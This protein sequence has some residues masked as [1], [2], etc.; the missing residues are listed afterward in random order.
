MK[1]QLFKFGLKNG[2][3][4][5]VTGLPFSPIK[6]PDA[7]SIGLEGATGR[8]LLGGNTQDIYIAKHKLSNPE[9]PITWR[10]IS[11]SPTNKYSETMALFNDNIFYEQ[12]SGDGVYKHEIAFPS[13]HTGSLIYP[14]VDSVGIAVESYGTVWVVD[15]SLNEIVG[16]DGDGIGQSIACSST[17]LS[18]IATDFYHTSPNYKIRYRVFAAD[19]LGKRVHRAT[20][21]LASN[22]LLDYSYYENIFDD[23]NPY[24]VGIDG[25]NNAWCFGMGTSSIVKIYRVE[26]SSVF[27]FG[28]NCRYPTCKLEDYEGYQNVMFNDLAIEWFL[29]RDPELMSAHAKMAYYALLVDYVENEVAVNPSYTRYFG[30]KTISGFTR[31]EKIQN[32]QDWNRTF[33]SDLNNC[34]GRKMFINYESAPASNL[35]DRYTSVAP[36]TYMSPP[37]ALSDFTGKVAIDST[38]LMV[39]MQRTEDPEHVH[40]LESSSSSVVENIYYPH[41]HRTYVSNCRSL[42]AINNP[43]AGSDTGMI[44][45]GHFDVCYDAYE[46][47]RS[48]KHIE[49]GGLRRNIVNNG[50]ILCDNASKLFSMGV[51]GVSLTLCL[52]HAITNGV[53]ETLT[54]EQ[55]SLI[56]DKLMWAVNM[57]DMY[58]TQPGLYAA[59]TPDG[60]E[61]TSWSH[62]SKTTIVDT[63]INVPENT[64]FTIDFVWN[65]DGLFDEIPNADIAIFLDGELKSWGSGEIGDDSFDELYKRAN[66]TPKHAEFCLMGNKSRLLTLDG[67]IR[68]IE[69]YTS[70]RLSSSSSSQDSLSSSSQSHELIGRGIASLPLSFWSSKEPV[71]NIKDVKFGTVVTQTTDLGLTRESGSFMHRF[72]EDKGRGLKTDVVLPELGIDLPP[73]F[74]L[75]FKL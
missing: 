60:I 75:V 40:V 59:F 57:G 10:L 58:I 27:P 30:G 3:L 45:S 16:I 51:G 14:S 36:L 46:Y 68:R 73:G 47:D 72:G 1:Q 28:G 12:R 22:T 35:G 25:F 48:D 23:D 9:E 50:I 53:Y 15:N 17:Y 11:R 43:M 18:G 26:N 70:P 8:L 71:V 31:L 63:S 37:N 49:Q 69:T 74:D 34:Q 2:K 65:K 39:D 20:Y 61:F 54:G 52:P 56:K 62:L 4:Y 5:S 13:I 7:R 42:S 67:I 41:R 55:Q 21:D 66:D 44:Y 33:G 29:L 38:V 6:D 19:Y 32:V 24:G 64:D